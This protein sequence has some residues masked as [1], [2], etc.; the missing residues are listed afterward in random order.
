MTKR[1][2]TV[3]VTVQLV[4][5]YMESTDAAIDIVKGI[6]MESGEDCRREIRHSLEDAGAKDVV[7]HMVA[8]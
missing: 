3:S 8:Y 5:M 6:M 1:K 4:D 2:I 7:I